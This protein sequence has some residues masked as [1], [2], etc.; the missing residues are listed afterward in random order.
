MLMEEVSKE[1]LKSVLAS[2]KRDQ[3]SR[4]NNW[5]VE[6][7]VGFHDVFVKDLLRV[8]EIKSL[9]KILGD[10]N[11]MFIALIPKKD[12][13]RIFYELKSISLCNC[14]Y[15]LV[16]E[17]IAIRVKK[18]LSEIISQAHL[19][20]LEGRHIHDAIGETQECLQ[21]IRQRKR[22]IHGNET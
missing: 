9:G 19:G 20:F 21:S 17:I 6:F 5:P 3:I 2:F 13:P 16:A 4:P 8:I 11:S 18:I 12:K 14:I 7:F 10:F 22:K 15:K 1:D